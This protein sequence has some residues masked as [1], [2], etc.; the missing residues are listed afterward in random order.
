LLPVRTW[1]LLPADL[2]EVR[3]RLP[4]DAVTGRGVVV[5]AGVTELRR[6]DVELPLQAVGGVQVEE[7]L[8][9]RQVRCCRRT[10]ASRQR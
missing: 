5:A 10:A 1:R 2:L 7:R 3:L 8:P 4:L 9:L 6:P